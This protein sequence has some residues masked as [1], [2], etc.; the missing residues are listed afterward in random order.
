M[1]VEFARGSSD[2]NMKSE[3]YFHV[4]NC[5]YY[6]NI[7]VDINTR[8][9]NGR[10]DYQLILLSNGTLEINENGNSIEMNAGDC[11]IFPPLAPQNYK[12]AARCDSAYYWIHF[13][14]T[15]CESILT[16]CKLSPLCIFKADDPERY[17]ANIKKIINSI[18][19]GRCETYINALAIKLISSA[20]ANTPRS[21]YKNVTLQMHSDIKHHIFDNDYAKVANVSK[22]YFIKC[23]K[24]E[25]GV[26][27][28]VYFN[29]LRL[30]KAKLL[31]SQT[32]MKIYDIAEELGFYDQFYFSKLFKKYIGVSPIKYKKT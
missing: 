8:R 17:I 16:D 24:A 32:N 6:K 4:T 15:A 7:D 26:T 29:N 20:C 5:G 1:R 21:I 23:F 9:P 31:L 11:Y 22:Y 30:E 13:S 3:S 27:P 12:V 19:E 18:R 25:L 28:N 2:S 14:G 10:L